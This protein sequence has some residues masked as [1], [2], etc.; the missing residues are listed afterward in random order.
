MEYEFDRYTKV[1]LVAG[2]LQKDNE[3][4]FAVHITSKFNIGGSANGGYLSAICVSALQESLSHPHPSVTTTYFLNRCYTDQ[5]A[6]VFVSKIR[7]TKRQSIAQARIVQQG[8]ERVR[9]LANFTTFDA[10]SPLTTVRRP[11]PGNPIEKCTKQESDPAVLQVYAR[12]DYLMEEQTRKHYNGAKD[13]SG[14]AATYLRFKDGREPDLKALSYFCDAIYPA[15]CNIHEIG[16]LFKFWIPTLELTVQYF[17]VPAPGYVYVHN[18]CTEIVNG[19]VGVE[20]SIWD[21]QKNL[22]AVTR[23]TALV[24]SLNI[25]N[26]KL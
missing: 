12:G 20:G 23:Q 1:Q 10:S 17:A 18:K 3:L 15:L 21:S 4:E 6:Q 9:M 24:S 5:D 26:N 7:I 19:S 14:V 8:E 2:D 22:V 25:S 16:D 13:H 11:F